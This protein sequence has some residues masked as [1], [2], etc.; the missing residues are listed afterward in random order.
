MTAALPPIWSV[1]SVSGLL[2]ARGQAGTIECTREGLEAA[3][4]KGFR[5]SRDLSCS[6][7]NHG[8]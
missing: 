7:P 5:R 4:F 3:G 6:R 1:R 2:L 8:N